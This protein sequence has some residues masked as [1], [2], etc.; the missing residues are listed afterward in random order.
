V[1]DDLNYIR[2]KHTL[3]FGYDFQSQWAS[4]LG[5][6][7]P[8]ATSFTSGSSFASF[9]LGDANAGITE[10][11]KYAAQQYRRRA[12]PGTPRITTTADSKS[13]SVS[14]TRRTP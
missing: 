11:H 10:T 5:A 2:G 1:K 7:V 6:S 8:A 3:K 4:F 12:G 14:S 13:R 9:L